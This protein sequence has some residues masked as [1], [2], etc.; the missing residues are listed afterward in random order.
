MPLVANFSLRR[1]DKVFLS[2]NADKNLAVSAIAW[3]NNLEVAWAELSTL[4]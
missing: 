1:S 3:G 2:V 4:S